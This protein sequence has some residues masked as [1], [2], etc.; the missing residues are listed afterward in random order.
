MK[1]IVKIFAVEV[2]SLFVATQIASGIVFQNGLEGLFVA[3]VALAIAAYF[4][5]PVVNVLLLPLNLVTLGLFR[6][7]GHAVTLF[8]VDLALNQFQITGFN[9]LG[10]TSRFFDIPAF[11]LESGAL[12]YIAFSI[13]ISVVSGLLS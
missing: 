3:G 9:F 5:R 4:V 6:F 8:I 1:K 2:V 7:I 13:L 10:M 12:S 11:N